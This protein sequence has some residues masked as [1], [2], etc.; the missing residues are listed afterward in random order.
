M[1]IISYNSKYYSQYNLKYQR[2]LLNSSETNFIFKVRNL[3]VNNFEKINDFVTPQKVKEKIKIIINQG[4]I[5]EFVKT[6]NR[7]FG[8]NLTLIDHFLPNILSEIILIF[9]S[10]NYSKITDLVNEIKTVNPLNYDLSDNH[11]FYTYKMKIFLNDVALGMLPSKVWNGNYE[12]KIGYI[13]VKKDGEVICNHIYDGTILN[14]DLLEHTKLETASTS[15]HNF[16]KL[17]KENGDLFIKLNL[18]IRFIN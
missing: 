7:I 13:I 14:D 16:G 5:L 6:E 3:S 11:D 8:N 1:K 18:Q 2:F 10:S 12:D 15:R 17:Y 9:Y 4:G